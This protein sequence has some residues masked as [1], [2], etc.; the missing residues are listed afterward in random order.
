[1][2]ILIIEDNPQHILSA[3]KFAKECGHE[4][5]MA[6]SYDEAE[7][8]LCGE[9]RFGSDK[10]IKN[11]DVVL[12]DLMLPVSNNGMAYPE[13]FLG[14]E[15]PYGLT[16]AFTA[17]RLG[18]KAIGILSGGVNHHHHPILWALDAMGGYTGKPFMIG[19]T[20]FLC[21]STGPWIEGLE[22][23]DPLYYAKDWMEFWL[24]LMNA[25]SPMAQL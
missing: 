18:T 21:S 10:P 20:T 24:M 6:K 13:K 8:A 16:L 15:Q 19:D 4:V 7:K 23:E 5:A 17:M 2:R 22:Q 1:M 12:T 25:R 9:N 3:E 11:F 14:T